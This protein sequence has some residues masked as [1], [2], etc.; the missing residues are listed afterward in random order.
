MFYNQRWDCR[1]AI[2]EIG[3][4]QGFHCTYVFLHGFCEDSR[5]W[6]D[7][8][9]PLKKDNRVILID[10]PGFGNSSLGNCESLTDYAMV[11]HDVLAEK[12]SM[13]SKIILV[14]HSLGGYVVLELMEHFPHLFAGATL[15]HSHPFGDTEEKKI[16][17][18][19]NIQFVEKNGSELFVKTLIPGLFSNQFKKENPAVVE[20]LIEQAKTQSKEGITKALSAMISRKVHTETLKNSQIPVQFIIGAEDEVIPLAQGV[21]QS[22]LPNVALIHILQA[23]AHQGMYEAPVECAQHLLEFSTF[24][25]SQHT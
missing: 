12:I 20:K 2:T 16:S 19:K 17:R 23:V 14:G 10:L 11:V 7:F 6:V 22:Y 4:T 21:A 13:E 8:V 24:I 9:Q 5:I 15:F 25:K 18:S 3:K 1:L